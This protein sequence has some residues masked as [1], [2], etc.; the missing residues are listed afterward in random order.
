ML[1]KC[2][3]CGA[4]I[5]PKWLLLAMPWSTYACSEC[6]TVFGGTPFRTVLSS[7]AVGVVGYIV[8]AVIKGRMAPTTLILPVAVALAVL[9]LRLPGQIR[10]VG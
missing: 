9:L 8:I 1:I 5:S 3:T 6:G 4:R 2:L 10:K 7:L